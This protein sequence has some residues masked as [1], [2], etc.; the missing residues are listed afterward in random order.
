MR[1]LNIGRAG[2]A[3]LALACV[4]VPASAEVVFDAA[5]TTG[6]RTGGFGCF[7]WA[8]LKAGYAEFDN[9]AIRYVRLTR[10]ADSWADM[11]A[12]RTFCSAR[13]IKWV[14]T[15]WQAPAQFK[16][17][18][19]MLKDPAG[20]ARHWKDVVAELDAHACRPEYVDL[21][22]EPDSKGVWS[23][24]IGPSE[25]NALIKAVRKEFDLAGYF[26]VSVAAPNLTSMSDWSG[27][28]Q[29]FAAMD[30]EATRSLTAFATHPWGDDVARAGCRGGAD[31]QALAWPG[32]GAS[33]RAKDPAK[34][35][36]I[37]EYATRQY[38]YDGMA[39]PDP[40]KVG[41]YNA[42]FSMPYAVR[43]YENTLS[44]LNLGATVPFYWDDADHPG[45]SKQWGWLDEKGNKKPIYETLRALYPKVAP[46]STVLK[47]VG[48][49]SVIYAGAFA[50]DSTIVVGLANCR[51][52]AHE[53]TVRIR[54]AAELAFLDG[55]AVETETRFDPAQKT[56]DKARVAARTLAFAR[57]A[58]GSWSARA[59]LPGYS[60][61]TV[62]LRRTASA[63]GL[64]PVSAGVK[65]PSVVGAARDAL[66]RLRPASAAD[67]AR[68]IRLP[69][70]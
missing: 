21:M 15:L 39:Y 53:A 20:F 12:F 13:G 37:L 51:K 46:G 10:D 66:G 35:L 32:F 1:K 22:N 5:D 65:A 2:A 59:S 44:F 57:S 6:P 29:Y 30:E 17:G 4:C 68:A 47:A 24:G 36:W 34:P 16:D 8:G 43:T 18:A 55:V 54:G 67:P 42:S 23:T 28:K 62:R 58:D 64:P 40:D 41:G 33:A 7:A 26:N 69:I 9:L 70:P 31:C 48:Q 45:S 50:H 27:P 19:N 61:L 11:Q 49:D 52:A 14:Y 38:S 25:M 60:V 3:A 63:V 56:A